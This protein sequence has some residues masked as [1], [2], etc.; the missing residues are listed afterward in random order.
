MDELGMSCVALID[1]PKTTFN[2]FAKRLRPNGLID[3]D[4]CFIGYYFRSPQFR[5]ILSSYSTMTTRASL[6]EDTI[7]KNCH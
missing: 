5:A 7:K 3:I 6:N 1:Y 2:G 4:P